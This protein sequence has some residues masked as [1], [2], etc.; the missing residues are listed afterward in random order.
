MA[1]Y[2]DIPAEMPGITL[3]TQEAAVA[4]EGDEDDME[5][6][7]AAAA[8]R[9]ADFG[10]SERQAIG[11]YVRQI[12][13][14]RERAGPNIVVN[15]DMVP[16]EHGE[17]EEPEEEWDDAVTYHTGDGSEEDE[18]D[19]LP[20]DFVDEDEDSSDEEEEEEEEVQRAPSARSRRSRPVR[21]P[22][23]M[24]LAQAV[25]GKSPGVHFGKVAGA[26]AEG[27]CAKA[28][29]LFG[30]MAGVDCEEAR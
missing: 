29:L 22:V 24:N 15:V 14:E 4:D 16:A 1:P 23:R 2:P 5:H 11:D 8:A 26:D 21:G 20:P 18:D 17:V 6:E 13:G 3:E 10:P 9:N 30:K 25:A 28:G 19:E 7:R 27:T 12:R